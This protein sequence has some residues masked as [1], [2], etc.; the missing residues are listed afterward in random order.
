MADRGMIPIEPTVSIY[1]PGQKAMLAWNGQ[2]EIMVLSTDV[3][4]TNST[5]VLEIMPL[6][7]N[8][9]K[10]E[11]GSFESFVRLQE[12]IQAHAWKAWIT[13]DSYEQSLSE[14]RSVQVTFHEKIGAHDITVV[15]ASDTSEFIEWMKKFLESNDVNHKVSL[16][17]FESVIVDY[18]S[19]GFRYYVLDLIEMA[20]QKNSVEPILYRFETDFLY[21][22]LKISSPI[23]GNTKITLFIL[24]NDILFDPSSQYIPTLIPSQYML[25]PYGRIYPLKIVPFEVYY[26]PIRLIY[27][28]S[29]NGDSSAVNSEIFKFSELIH[30]NLTN[31]ELNTIDLRIGEL[32]ENGAWLTVLEY[33]GALNFLNRDLMIAKG[34]GTPTT[35]AGLEE[36]SYIILYGIFGAVAMLTSATL[37]SLIIYLKQSKKEMRTNKKT[38]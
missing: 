21:Y 11:K 9:K 15:N 30:F 3:Q 5:F 10:I 33:E 35:Y 25:L 17:K 2:E 27:P 19:R 8:P 38:T 14:I 13:S 31:S 34:G 32:F 7:S 16:D 23:S 26:R 24:A 28:N 22:P 12:L 37:A 6:P 18:M 29:T 36:P 4:A 1:E 20:S